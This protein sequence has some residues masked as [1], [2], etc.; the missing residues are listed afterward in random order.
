MFSLAKHFVDNNL[1][2]KIYYFNDFILPTIGFGVNFY[3]PSLS[4]V[5][6]CLSEGLRSLTKEKYEQAG[7]ELCQAQ[8]S[9]S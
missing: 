5:S 7:A 3:A 4:L 8:S 6:I 1:E 9:F 2:T